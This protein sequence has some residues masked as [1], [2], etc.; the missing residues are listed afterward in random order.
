M[1]KVGNTYYVGLVD[2]NDLSGIRL[3]IFYMFD[4]D[5]YTGVYVRWN[6][7]RIYV[8]LP[9]P[10]HTI[11]AGAAQ[12]IRQTAI[13]YTNTPYSSCFRASFVFPNTMYWRF[14]S[15]TFNLKVYH[16]FLYER[17]ELN[18]DTVHVTTIWYV[19]GPAYVLLHDA[20][21]V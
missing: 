17:E 11:D 19:H 7:T 5:K 12:Y 3:R 18:P 10:R 20:V 4:M 13:G 2:L 21:P 14:L 9:I 6:G 15:L 1:V 8:L 16:G